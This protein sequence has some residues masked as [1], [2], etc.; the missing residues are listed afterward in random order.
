[1]LSVG[2]FPGNLLSPGTLGIKNA[3]VRIVT[4]VA[5]KNPYTFA[6]RGNAIARCGMKRFYW[7][8]DKD[9]YGNAPEWIDRDVCVTPTGFV[10]NA[11]DCDDTNPAVHP[12]AAE[13]C[14][15]IDDDCDGQIDEGF[16]QNTFYRDV[17]VDGYG[18]PAVTIK[19]CVAPPG[20]VANNQ[21]CND[22]NS[23]AHPGATEVCNG[24][25]DD[26]DGQIDEGNIL[27][28]DA[29]R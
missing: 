17:D 19:A 13:T 27:Y 25:D 9:G 14:N 3:T 10:E 1:M 24:K 20:Y 21:D 22:A 23:D 4:N 18:N 16:T 15:G 7:D 26:C 6:I 11:L 28:R 29:R 5:D 12:G 2:F 8:G